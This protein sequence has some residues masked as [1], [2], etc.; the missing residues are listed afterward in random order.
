MK[1][2]ST[3]LVLLVTS[4]LGGCAYDLTNK[5]QLSLYE[6][7]E[8]KQYVLVGS[9]AKTWDKELACK[10]GQHSQEYKDY[11][12]KEVCPNWQN[13]RMFTGYLY[14][15]PFNGIKAI[16]ALTPT[17][18]NLEKDDIAEVSLLIREDGSP[19]RPALLTRVARKNKDTGPDCRWQGG[20]GA[21]SSFISGGVVCDGWDWKKQKFA[22]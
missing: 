22:R 5:Q 9:V 1:T 8:S 13:L 4:L 19:A 16:T 17:T 14:T 10:V 21:T 12:A 15:H 11:V 3:L 6:V 18:V 7:G 20:K 2:L